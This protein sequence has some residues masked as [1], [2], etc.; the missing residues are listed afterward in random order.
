VRADPQYSSTNTVPVSREVTILE[1]AQNTTVFV[2]AGTT[3]TAAPQ[4]N[5]QSTALDRSANLIVPKQNMI[6]FLSK[7]HIVDDFDWNKTDV[8]LTELSSLELPWALFAAND[9]LWSKV[10]NFSGFRGDVIVRVQANPSMAHSGKLLFVF[11]PLDYVLDYST[12]E[13]HFTSLTQLPKMEFDLSTDRTAQMTIPYRLPFA[14]LSLIAGTSSSDRRYGK[15]KC[16]VYSELR[17]GTTDTVPVTMWA[18]F[19]PATVVLCNPTATTTTAPTSALAPRSRVR[20]R[21]KPQGFGLLVAASAGL[22]GP[23]GSVSFD[24]RETKSQAVPSSEM[25]PSTPATAQ[26]ASNVPER[27]SAP[28]STPW[29]DA[30]RNGASALMGASN[31]RQ[32]VAPVLTITRQSRDMCTVDQAVPCFTYAFTGSA[33]VGAQPPGG[34]FTADELHFGHLLPMSTYRET[35]SWE[36]TDGIGHKLIDLESID[37][38]WGVQSGT[39]AKHWAPWCAI[40]SM[41]RYYRGTIRVTF[42][43]AKSRFHSGRLLVAF[44]CDPAINTLNIGDTDPLLRTVIDLEAGNRFD[45]ECPFPVVHDYTET[46]VNVGKL[47]LFVL[48]PLAYAGGASD[49]IDIIIESSMRADA[50]FAFPRGEGS[51]Y[52]D[53]WL[54]PVAGPFAKTLSSRVRSLPTARVEAQGFGP[55]ASAV[56]PTDSISDVQLTNN[57]KTPFMDPVMREVACIGD[58]CRTL[59]TLIKRGS[60][61]SKTSTTPSFLANAFGAW[62]REGNPTLYIVGQW[63]CLFRGS[64]RYTIGGNGAGFYLFLADASVGSPPY[65]SSEG[66][67]FAQYVPNLIATDLEVPMMALNP[68]RIV[69]DPA[70]APTTIDFRYPVLRSS[71]SLSFNHSVSTADDFDMSFFIGVSPTLFLVP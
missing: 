65:T 60:I 66:T 53:E 4:T 61:V 3:V 1:Q 55:L 23:S 33:K 18:W 30:I 52:I 25:V 29:A 45:F 12:R 16:F 71:T 34:L 35:I 10:A 8:P 39:L 40:A 37:G 56:L 48:T 38:V 67:A 70:D 68:W 14:F 32:E 11:E 20:P 69:I 64:M 62:C 58:V 57:I 31:P 15:L 5:S 41:F 13:E 43:I 17:G 51:P 26:S 2:D 42:N 27:P 9:V 22:G 36:S 19:D 6:D 63:Y 7:P 21:P 46:A 28:S 44:D 47:S 49:T 59:R 54:H 50:S 24:S